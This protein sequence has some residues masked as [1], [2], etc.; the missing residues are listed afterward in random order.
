MFIVGTHLPVREK[1]IYPAVRRA[2]TASL[3][4]IVLACAMAPFVGALGGFQRPAIITVLLAASS[5]AIVLPIVQ[6]GVGSDQLLCTLAWVSM[7]D[8]ITVV[9][10]PLVMAS[11][12]VTKAIIGSVLVIAGALLVGLLARGVL[13]TEP[14]ERLRKASAAN[15][16][17]LD[18]R[19]SLL[20]LF[21]LAWIAQRFQTS[22]LI[23]GFAAG[24]VVAALDPPERV[25]QQLIGIGQG[26][27]IPLFFVMLGAGIDLRALFRSAQDIRLLILLVVA[28]VGAHVVAALMHRLPFSH[29]LLAS[30]QLGV[31]V[32]VASIGLQTHQ[33]LPSEAAAVV[34]SSVVTLAV[35]AIGA[36]MAG[37]S[38][39]ATHPSRD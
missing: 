39:S 7:L 37:F 29:G 31:P 23:A 13:D 11:G 16:F 19:L 9:A 14:V 26:F 32:A 28:G 36:V 3:V 35:A 4:T 5:A 18:L 2:A 30:A 20:V 1:R 38:P 8:I 25:T 22:I 27:F 10:V 12:T 15:G 24:V 6:S 33:L 17:A 34:G 21:T